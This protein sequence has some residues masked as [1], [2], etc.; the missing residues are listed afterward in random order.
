MKRGYIRTKAC[1]KW[2]NCNWWNFFK[3]KKR[4]TDLHLFI[5]FFSLVSII[6]FNPSDFITC[7][8]KSSKSVELLSSI[9][10]LSINWRIRLQFVTCVS[11]RA[12]SIRAHNIYVFEVNIL[13]FSILFDPCIGILSFVQRREEN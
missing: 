10:I 8:D 6:V 7:R 12:V 13:L 11:L 5:H 4:K 9:G 1:N 2:F 3:K